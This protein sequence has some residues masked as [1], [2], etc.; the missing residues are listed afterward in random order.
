MV[1]YIH[2]LICTTRKILSFLAN[3][4]K[5]IFC[6]DPKKVKKFRAGGAYKVVHMHHQLYTTQPPLK[7]N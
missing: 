2:H 5:K 4:D 3:Y 6:V 1:V 7:I